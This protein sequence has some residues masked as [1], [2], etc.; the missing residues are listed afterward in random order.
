MSRTLRPADGLGS[1]IRRARNQQGMT[2][3]ELA[4]KAG[5]SR[6]TV[7]RVELGTP[8]STTTLAKV[9]KALRLKVELRPDRP[10]GASA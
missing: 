1:E 7:A 4:V 2:Q 6:P 9:A 8:I 10:R 5:V 3:T